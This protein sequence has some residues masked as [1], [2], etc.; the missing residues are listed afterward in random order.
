MFE[1][2][3]MLSELGLKLVFSFS[4]KLKFFFCEKWGRIVVYKYG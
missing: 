1:I 4:D 2:V 3:I